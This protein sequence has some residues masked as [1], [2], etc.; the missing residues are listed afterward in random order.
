[1]SVSIAEMRELEENRNDPRSEH[2]VDD[3]ELMMHAADIT[4]NVGSNKQLTVCTYAD[5]NSVD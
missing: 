4:R 3:E 1:M 5:S 2:T